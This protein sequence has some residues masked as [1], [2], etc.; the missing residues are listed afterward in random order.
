MEIIKSIIMGIVQGLTEFLPVSSSGHLAIFNRILQLDTTDGILFE[1]LLHVGTLVAIVIAFFPDIV[2]LVREGIKLIGRLA[3]WPFSKTKSS[4]IRNNYDRFV[5]LIIIST[6]PTVI[7]GLL[8]E[9]MVETAF[10]SLIIP[11][12]G[13]L[14]TGSLLLISLKFENGTRNEGDLPYKKG[15]VVGIAQGLAVIPGISRSGSTMVAGLASGMERQFAVKY[16]FIM[17]LPAVL[18]A[19]VLKLN[20][21]STMSLASNTLFAYLLGTVAS[22]VVGYL[23]IRL[24]LDIIRKK[25]LH[26]FAYY[27]YAVG[28]LVIG[29]YFI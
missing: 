16:S 24:L 21:M 19:A 2:E 18:G 9:K 15:F 6:I 26:Y 7:I 28:I 23:C 17:S 5:L 14:I 10:S 25:K 12:I 27:C 3:A 8:L 13:L 1:V 20:D 22:A 11:G 29:A 4:P